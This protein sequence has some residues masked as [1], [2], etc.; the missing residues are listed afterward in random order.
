MDGQ[1]R[2]QARHRRHCLEMTA[3]LIGLNAILLA[4]LF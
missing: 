4:N 1:I 3:I 2:Q